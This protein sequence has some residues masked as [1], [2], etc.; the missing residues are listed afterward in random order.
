MDAHSNELRSACVCAYVSAPAV[1]HIHAAREGKRKARYPLAWSPSQVRPPPPQQPPPP[2][3]CISVRFASSFVRFVHVYIPVP[4]CSVNQKQQQWGKG[5][6]G[7]LHKARSPEY[8]RPRCRLYMD[9]SKKPPHP[10]RGYVYTT[11]PAAAPKGDGARGSKRELELASGALRNIYMRA[12]SRE[13]VSRSA[14]SAM[15]L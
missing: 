8:A 1:S 7:A 12:R 15:L 10:R 3:S 9:R 2:P 14:C 5:G 13:R 11:R 6:V 4:L